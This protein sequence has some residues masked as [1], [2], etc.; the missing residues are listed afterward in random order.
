MGTNYSITEQFGA[1]LANLL[2]EKIMKV[3]SEFDKKN[4][5]Q[6]VEN[7]VVEKTYTQRIAII[8][9][10]LKKYLP[11]EYDKALPILV[12]ILG[13]EN[14]NQTGM[15]T[16][17][18]WI[19]PIGKF[20]QEYGLDHFDFSIKAI[21]E[22]TKR[23]TG[24]YA[25]RPYIRKYPNETIKVMRKWAK[26]PS[27]HLR[28][29]ASEGLRPKLPWVSKLDTFLENPTPVFQILELLKEDEIMF[30]KKSV[31]NHITDWIKVNKDAVTPLI[32]SW[33]TS[34]NENTKWIIKRATRK[35]F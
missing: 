6:D 7:S 15:F 5:I 10:L 13:E 18:Y 16:F 17:Y 11:S 34:D 31:A 14:P 29:L 27:F 33:K 28:R 1:N 2:S 23:N 21:E 8:A 35:D 30:V 24:E 12:S 9:E 32:E 19:L 22:I 26:S 3:Y 4:F 20:V 25:I